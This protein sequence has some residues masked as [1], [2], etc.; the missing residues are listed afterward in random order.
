[1]LD[2]ENPMETKLHI[3]GVTAFPGWI[4]LEAN[5]TNSP[6]FLL[7]QVKSFGDEQFETIYLDHILAIFSSEQLPFF[8]RSIQRVLAKTGELQLS[9]RDS[10][11]QVSPSSA[12]GIYRDQHIETMLKVNG[13]NSEEPIQNGFTAEIIMNKL[14]AA[15]FTHAVRADQF[16]YCSVGTTTAQIHLR[17]F[18]I[19]PMELNAENFVQLF[20]SGS[21]AFV[22][23]DY[24][25]AYDC[26]SKAKSIHGNN[27]SLLYN[28][29]LTVGKMGRIEESVALFN[30]VLAI[31]PQF[32]DA[33]TLRDAV[34]NEYVG[35]F[36]GTATSEPAASFRDVMIQGITF[37]NEGR[38]DEARSL[39]EAVL[40]ADPD[41]VP[42]LHSLGVLESVQ[43]NHEKAIVLF[44]K[45]V[46]L[47][48]TDAIGWYNLAI[49]HQQL[50]QLTQSL[51]C[52]NRA[53]EIDPGHKSVL[54]N[55]GVVFSALKRHKEA[56]MSFEELLAL[57]P[58]NP[59]VLANRAV[60]LG[61][62]KMYDMAIQSY[63]RL[64]T[65]KPDY[66]FGWGMLTFEKLY[67]CDW[68]D[69][70]M[71]LDTIVSG[72]RDGKRVCNPLAFTA[73]SP[74]PED[75]YRCAT[76]FANSYY[77]A[78]KPLWNGEMYIHEKIRIAYVSPDFREHPVAHLTA[79]LFE[80]HN[81]DRF[82]LTAFSMGLDDESSLRKRIE[83]TFDSFIDIR[84]MSTE[85]V[86]KLIRSLEID[87]L[88]DLAGYTADSRTDIFAYKPAPVQVNFLGYS[89]TMGA[90]YYDYLIGDRY[91]IP[92]EAYQWFSEKIVT[93]PDTY[94]PTDTSL[95]FADIS[96]SREQYNLPEKG[97]VFCC[98][99]H[100]YKISPAV[101]AVWMRLLSAVPDSVIW[102]M[103]LNEHAEKNLLR[104]AKLQG[105]DPQRIIFAT[106]VPRIE[107]H[108]ARYRCA[109]L[110]LDTSPCNGHSTTSDVLRAGLP[111]ITCRG[112]TFAGRV[113]S[114]LLE[115]VGLS[116][117]ITDSLDQYETLALA[118]ALD[119]ARLTNVKGKL[120]KNL[121]EHN[122]F[123]TER[124][125]RN[126]E[127]A[128]ETMYQ[129][130]QN[131]QEP[132]HFS[133]K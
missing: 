89:N 34:W 44:E 40:A 56:L 50:K 31:D 21:E 131:G 121:V 49:A 16:E 27:S 68:S 105:I 100:D 94:L 85:S 71:L 64:L 78:K 42:A 15:G 46:H 38:F 98:F 18:K 120:Q 127:Q 110:Y 14:G 43:N 11:L 108:L 77:P 88:I 37:Q 25:T 22:N 13:S 29:A 83:S 117:L 119:P 109:D 69:L 73:M 113:A 133:V 93:M 66:D 59:G 95:R 39:F 75:H 47:N 10:S 72:L 63:K 112:K 4:N 103:K 81:R 118:L 62:F 116:E 76:I 123:D 111:V 32:R 53:Y 45:M 82:E 51:D 8:L 3:G 70:D 36:S 126:L 2:S 67:A 6:E 17:L 86:A 1:M 12:Q 35:K 96:P 101:F 92:Q 26:F 65:V 125:C 107:D 74:D 115:V 30:D 7:E 87:I 84:E 132:E 130:V 60:I 122:P 58:D 52:Y 9:V 99:N 106:R 129:R 48:P 102:L 33:E 124:F 128:F 23:G 28:L 79:G 57:D 24:P 54:M 91:I 41:C 61:D 90:Q 97:F 19:N 20:N 80:L 114:A 5:S 104:E 55:R